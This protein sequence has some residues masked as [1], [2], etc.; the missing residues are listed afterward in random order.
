VQ[1]ATGAAGSTGPQG[2]AG[3]TGP[4]G[5]TG[6]TGPQGPQGSGISGYAIVTGTASG[7]IEGARTVTSTCASG[8]VA[9]GGGWITT[10][11]SSAPD[12]IITASYPS[13]TTVW[14]VTGTSYPTNGDQSYVLQAY[15]I[16]ATEP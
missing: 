12:T 7:D 10:S 9:V 1:G 13:S 8:K 3:S 11:V 4:Q 16:C 15:V 2:A 5:A 14:T 6:A